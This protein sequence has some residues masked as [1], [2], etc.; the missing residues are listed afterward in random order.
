MFQ[1]NGL[2]EWKYSGTHVQTVW[3]YTSGNIQLMQTYA[4]MNQV[5]RS[6]R[7]M[8]GWTGFYGVQAIRKG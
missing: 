5:T 7:V 2:A 1:R 4:D 6:R 8:D 3:K